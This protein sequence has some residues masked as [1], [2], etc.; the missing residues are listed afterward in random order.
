FLSIDPVYGGNANAY[1][2]VTADPL[3]KYDL[4]GRRWGWIGRGW[5][6]VKRGWGWAKRTYNNRKVYVNRVRKFVDYGRRYPSAGGFIGGGFG[7][8]AC[9]WKRP[10]WSACGSYIARGVAIGAS[11][12][13]GWGYAKATR[14]TWQWWRARRR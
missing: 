12:G 8:A 9:V 11:I 1:E 13:L 4:D 6:Q 7:A 10:G 5:G 14:K 3:N 2:Y